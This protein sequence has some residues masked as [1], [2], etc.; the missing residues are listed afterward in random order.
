VNHAKQLA[1]GLRQT[2]D[3][4]CRRAPL[5]LRLAVLLIAAGCQPQPAALVWAP[6]NAGL[7]SRASVLTLAHDPAA[8]AT[9]FAGVDDAA[10]LYRSDDGGQTWQVAATGLPAQPVYTLLADRH[11]PGVLLAGSAD[12]IYQTQDGGGRWTVLRLGE[13]AEP[14][15]VYALAQDDRGAIFLGGN[16]SEIWRSNDGGVNWQPLTPLPDDATVLALAAAPDGQYLLAGTDR[17]GV[18]FSTDQGRSWQRGEDMEQTAVAALLFP[19]PGNAQVVLA[20]GRRELW[21]S[22][23]GARTWQPQAVAATGRI[24]ALLAHDGAAFLL[25]NEGELLRSDDLGQSWLPWGAGLGR[26]GSA[27]LLAATAGRNTPLWAG[28]EHRLYRSDD[29]GQTWSA[30]SRGPGR[31]EAHALAFDGATIYLANRD[32]LYAQSA[33]GNAW[34]QRTGLPAGAVW[35]VAAAPGSDGAAYAATERQGLWQS[36]RPGLEWAPTGQPNSTPGIVLHP[37]DP[38]QI[39]VHVI[40]ERVYASRDAGATWTPRWE[41]FDL[42]TEIA[43]LMLDPCRPERL[44]AGGAEQLYRSLDSAASWQPIAPELAGQTVFALLTDC[45]DADRLLA[46]AT[47]GVYRSDDG[48]A[49]WQPG[50]LEE[51]TVTALAHHPRAGRRLFAGTRHAGVFLSDDGGATWRPGGLDGMHVAQLLMAPD[52]AWLAAA[53]DHGFFWA[54]P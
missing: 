44:F 48:G 35:A 4:G 7:M 33:W 1:Y 11:R 22:T 45:D 43:S 20:R 17:R 32:G 3:G 23:D 27:P 42:S 10:G 24:D 54:A 25:T 37:T 36:Q 52:G 15:A 47:K 51:I 28:T 2:L 46:G 12:G 5:A 14:F 49:S 30:P 31:Y 53:T 39:Y 8:P 18:Y 29:G 19:Q 16:R 26:R 21:R 13:D 9:L 34:V 38:Q 6:H 40:Y 50:G 41:G